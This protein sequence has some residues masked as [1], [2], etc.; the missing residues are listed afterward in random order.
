MASYRITYW[1]GCKKHEVRLEFLQNVEEIFL[2]YELLSTNSK[3]ALSHMGKQQCILDF[4]I[5][6]RSYSFTE[7]IRLFFYLF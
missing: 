1:G 2:S 3:G 4:L 6:L 7:V 5:R